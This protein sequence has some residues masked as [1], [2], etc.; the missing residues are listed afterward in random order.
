VRGELSIFRC[1]TETSARLS[2]KKRRNEEAKIRK[3]PYA[4]A[5][6]RPQAGLQG[7]RES[8]M[9]TAPDQVPLAFVILD[10]LTREARGGGRV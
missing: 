10:S 4:S 7:V 2:A 8:Q 3:L 1:P 5:A 6:S 9:Q